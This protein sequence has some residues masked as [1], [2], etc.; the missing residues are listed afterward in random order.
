MV[1]DN[2]SSF[3]AWSSDLMTKDN[4]VQMAIPTINKINN[5]MIGINRFKHQITNHKGSD[6]VNCLGLS[7]NLKEFDYKDYIENRET[8][9]D[10]S[11]V[12]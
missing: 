11:R 1:E 7:T 6:W 5:T 10:V 4:D 12:F 9:L 8:C 3:T 2:L